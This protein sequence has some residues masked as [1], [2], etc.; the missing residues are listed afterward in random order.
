MATKTTRL[1]LTKKNKSIAKVIFIQKEDA[2]DIK[3][4]IP[5][6]DYYIKGYKL[7]NQKP[8]TGETSKN[9]N[10]EI[11][12][13]YHSKKGDFAPKIHFKIIDNGGVTYKTMP[14]TRL[15]SPTADSFSPFP[16]FKIE[17][18]D[19]SLGGFKDVDGSHHKKVTETTIND[20]H[21]VI[22]VYIVSKDSKVLERYEPYNKLLKY[23]LSCNFEYFCTN[24]IDGNKTPFFFKDRDY[25][26]IKNMMVSELSNF[27]V[28]V[29]S[30]IFPSLE[31]LMDKPTVTFVENELSDAIFHHSLIIERS[32][33]VEAGSYL[34]GNMS[35][36]SLLNVDTNGAEKCWNKNSLSYLLYKGTRDSEE[37]AI[38]KKNALQYL[39]EL[40]RE[41]KK[42]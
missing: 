17:I 36:E 3:V 40:S 23:F 2:F 29:M 21:K 15:S 4:C 30:S 13:S 20:D 14:L 41:V 39:L 12:V 11:E 28:I 8:L 10:M 34:I 22:E 26:S 25:S 33:R 9:K 27:R 35:K 18:P 37:R 1:E 42:D 5:C 32:S 16:L 24:K 7:F 19:T 31:K 38:I 6:S